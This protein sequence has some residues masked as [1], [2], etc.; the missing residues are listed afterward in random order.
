[1]RKL[2]LNSMLAATVATAVLAAAPAAQAVTFDWSYTGVDAGVSGGGTMQATYE[3]SDTY[4]ITSIS[5]TA[6]GQTISGLSGYGGADQTVFYPNPP[7]VVVDTNGFGFKVGNGS[8][9]YNIYEDFGNFPT[10]P[11]HCGAAYC[12][13][14][15]GDPS[16]L[17]AGDP[18][19]ALETLTLTAVPEPSTWA[20]LLLG[21]ASLGYARHRAARLA[22]ALARTTRP[23]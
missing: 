4:L 3:G 16:T 9:A 2:G 18:V 21:F 7:N 8:T 19:F 12:I 15:P 23:S 5:G 22:P 20:M 14:G 10:G 1:M 11:Y 13:I 17:G 6:N